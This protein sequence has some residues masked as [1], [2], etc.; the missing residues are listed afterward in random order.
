MLILKCVTQKVAAEPNYTEEGIVP[1]FRFFSEGLSSVIVSC[2]AFLHSISL[3]TGIVAAQ[4][5]LRLLHIIWIMFNRSTLPGKMSFLCPIL[6]F[7]IFDLLPLLLQFIKSPL[8][9]QKCPSIF[10]LKWSLWVMSCTFTHIAVLLASVLWPDFAALKRLCD[11]CLASWGLWKTDTEIEKTK[12]TVQA[13]EWVC[14]P[15]LACVCVR[16]LTC[17]CSDVFSF[18]S[19][20]APAH[21]KKQTMAYCGCQWKF[22]CLGQKQ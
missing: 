21:G 4:N 12:D 6:S 17:V 15:A 13:R 1:A 8:F 7:F 18:Y 10:S 20:V 2:A 3:Y 16:V 11:L 9:R 5:E 19:S 14:A 22:L